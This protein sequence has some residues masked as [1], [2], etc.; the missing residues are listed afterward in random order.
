MK[1]VEFAERTTT[2][3]EGSRSCRR[4]GKVNFANVRNYLQIVRN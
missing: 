2:L 4:I 3:S 1:R